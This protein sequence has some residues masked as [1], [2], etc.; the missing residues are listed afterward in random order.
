MKM[1]LWTDILVRFKVRK[2]SDLTAVITLSPKAIRC[3]RAL[4][5]LLNG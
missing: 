5:A 2:Q 3:F 1:A 4:N